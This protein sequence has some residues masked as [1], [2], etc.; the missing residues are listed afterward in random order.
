MTLGIESMR[1]HS[2]SILMLISS[3]V[4][5]ITG[6]FLGVL[7]DYKWF[8]N[9]GALVVLC[10]VASEYSLIQL[11]F[12]ALYKSLKGQGAAVAGN[13]GVPDLT[14]KKPHSILANLSHIVIVI[15]TL[16]WG[17]GEW[18]LSWYFQ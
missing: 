1:K 9:F 3:V 7:N 8:G 10:G 17:F 4:S 13:K 2:F 15:G 6:L 11:E 5:I 16:I 14:P 12:K 18:Y